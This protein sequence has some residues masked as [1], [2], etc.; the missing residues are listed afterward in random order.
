[1]NGLWLDYESDGFPANVVPQGRNQL[2]VTVVGHQLCEKSRHR[3]GHGAAAVRRQWRP[4]SGAR[5]NPNVE[6][7]WNDVKEAARRFGQQ[8]DVV[9]V[10]SKADLNAAFAM[11]VQ[12]N[13]GALLVAS[14]SLFLS[15]S[16]QIVAL[17]AHHK[18]PTIYS[19]R[20]PVLV[21]RAHELCR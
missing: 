3:E 16:E 7:Q 17:A 2:S 8:V 20:E 12:R 6:P 19:Q 10:A 15:L 18:I 1:M 11:L 21:G 9:S 13:A 4:E 14:D 5:G